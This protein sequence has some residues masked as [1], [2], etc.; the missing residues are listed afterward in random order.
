MQLNSRHLLG[1]EGMTRDE[2]SLILDTAV[3]L[4]LILDRPIPKVPTLRG[5]TVVNLFYEASTRTR[6]SFELAEKRLSADSISFS[7]STSSVMKANRSRTRHNIEAMKVDTVMIRHRGGRRAH[8]LSNRL[9][10][11]V[12]NAGA[13]LIDT[14]QALLDMTIRRAGSRLRWPFSATSCT[15]ASRVAIFTGSRPQ[16][17]VAYAAAP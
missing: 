2:I 14:T 3:S 17:E 8:F 7:A 10:S 13:A 1:L 12:I 6:F 11:S 16:S 9:A 15:A 5:K 4:K